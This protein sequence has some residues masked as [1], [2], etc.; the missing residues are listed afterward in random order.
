MT[1][2]WDETMEDYNLRSPDP[3]PFTH[4]VVMLSTLYRQHRSVNK[5]STLLRVDRKT[6]YRYM[7]AF[8]IPIQNRTQAARRST[9]KQERVLAILSKNPD[10]TPAALA[11]AANVSTTLAWYYKNVRKPHPQEAP[12]P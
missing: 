2:R 1:I 9:A 11:R 8:G 4:H 6:L 7:H 5:V 10:I 12:T 3:S